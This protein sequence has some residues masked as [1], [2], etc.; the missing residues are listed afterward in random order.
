MDFKKYLIEMSNYKTLFNMIAISTNKKDLDYAEKT[1]ETANKKGV[2]HPKEYKRLKK[3]I[4]S[5]RKTI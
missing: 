4:I 5:L 2:I 1:V 3:E